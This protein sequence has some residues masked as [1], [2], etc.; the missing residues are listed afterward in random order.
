MKEVIVIILQ[1][2]FPLN[3]S[4]KQFRI[5]SDVNKHVKL[6]QFKWFTL[7]IKQNHV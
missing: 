4:E 5:L 3:F 7:R 6:V 2:W 1:I